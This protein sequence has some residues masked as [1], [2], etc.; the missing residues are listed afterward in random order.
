MRRAWRKAISV[1]FMTFIAVSILAAAFI[2]MYLYLTQHNLTATEAQRIYAEAAQERLEVILDRRAGDILINNTG[3]I[4]VTLKYLVGLDSSSKTADIREL[5]TPVT[6]PAGSSITLHVTEF[7]SGELYVMS[8]RG[9]LFKAIP[10]G[11]SFELEASPADITLERGGSAAITLKLKA[12]LLETPESGVIL[13][14]ADTSGCKMTNITTVTRA[15]NITYSTTAVIGGRAVGTVTICTNMFIWCL[16]WT[17]ITYVAD[18]AIMTLANAS[19]VYTIETSTRINNFVAQPEPITIT[20]TTR[21]RATITKTV[22]LDAISLDY[23]DESAGCYVWFR[24]LN[25]TS[26]SRLAEAGVRVAAVTATAI[27]TTT[28]TTAPVSYVEINVIQGSVS[29]GFNDDRSVNIEVI[30]RN[31]YEGIVTLSFSESDDVIHVPEGAGWGFDENPVTL[32]AGETKLVNF[33]FRIRG[34]GTVTISGSAS[35]SAIVIPDQFTVI[36]QT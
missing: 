26:G 9:N 34:S 10:G 6:I 21:T 12:A 35:P 17:T 4:G 28:E 25:A 33:R 32:S 24:V 16:G 3:G 27:T 20:L 7:P 19:V 23:W 13:I 36:I 29:G 15:A 14:V 1:M 30:S 2:T 8:E 11:F 22:T 31:G 18:P 5:S